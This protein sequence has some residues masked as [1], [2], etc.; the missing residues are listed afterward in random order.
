MDVVREQANEMAH[1]YKK[2]FP[3]DTKVGFLELIVAH[4][5][6]HAMDIQT[7]EEADKHFIDKDK[8]NWMGWSNRTGSFS[9]FDNKFGW[10]HTLEKT[11]ETISGSYDREV[12]QTVN[13]HRMDDAL[14]TECGEYSPTGYG[15]TNPKEDFAESF[16]IAALGGDTARFAGRTKVIADALVQ[17][18]GSNLIGPQL[19]KFSKLN[20]EDGV[21]RPTPKHT[22]LEVDVLVTDQQKAVE[23]INAA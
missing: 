10:T 8:Y 18:E 15:R 7:I 16:A 12:E 23:A 21:Y 1:R 22:R 6:G 11:K 13:V 9:V 2:Y 4:E 3:E 19:V 20:C 5:L 17:A 14:E